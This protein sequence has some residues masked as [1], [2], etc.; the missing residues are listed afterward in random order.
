MRHI[1]PIVT[2]FTIPEA[3]D[4]MGVLKYLEQIGR[5]CYKSEDKIT[6]E[7]CVRFIQNL[8]DRKHWAML[9]HYVFVMAIPKEVFDDITDR[10]WMTA[11]NADAVTY[12][13]FIH[14][15]YWS[16]APTSEMEYLVSGSATAFNYLQA[17]K[18]FNKE[19]EY[20]CGVQRI[21]HYMASIHPHLMGN[22]YDAR[23]DDTGIRFLDRDEISSL[24]Y[25]LKLIHEFRS[26]MITTDRGVT[27]ELVRHRP[28]SWAQES[29]RYCNYSKEKFGGEL[30][31]LT[32]SFYQDEDRNAEMMVWET[33]M[34]F[35]EMFYSELIKLGSTAQEARSVLPHSTKV[36][37]VITAL[38]SEFRHF[39]KM[40]CPKSAHP[41]MREV[42]IPMLNLFKNDSDIDHV[43]WDLF[44]E[45]INDDLS[46]IEA[47]RF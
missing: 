36:D 14:P 44:C 15:T 46:I 23:S 42:A 35:D 47:T 28:A 20:N 25:D 9:E 41:Q 13:K 38:L 31:T 3:T 12:M 22:N 19:D 27:H 43:F 32:P 1:K 33:A 4:E 24:P 17:C 45:N 7:S 18:C 37:I 11:E 8:F 34:K 6:D 29:T 26:V 30:T 40:R 2:G 16:E 39:F 21:Y 10:R 5:V